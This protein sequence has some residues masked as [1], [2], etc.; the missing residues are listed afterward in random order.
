[1]ISLSHE[2]I[3]NYYKTNFAMMQHHNYSLSDL[4]TMIPW[5]REIYIQMLVKHLEQE[6]ERNRALKNK[7]RK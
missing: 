6:K 4:E 7:M 5:E 1:L 2:S 3:E